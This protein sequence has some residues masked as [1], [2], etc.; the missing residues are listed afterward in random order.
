MAASLPG[1]R[2]HISGSSHSV[3]PHGHFIL[4][5]LHF[6]I[7]LPPQANV[8]SGKVTDPLI[9]LYAFV[10]NPRRH[11]F[12]LVPLRCL[13]GWLD[14]PRGLLWKALSIYCLWDAARDSLE[15]GPGDFY[16]ET[17]QLKA[18]VDVFHRVFFESWEGEAGSAGKELS[19]VGGGLSPPPRFTEQQVEN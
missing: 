9:P 13:E 16:G 8:T 17:S 7:L 5:R 6:L 11:C 10:R 14:S 19:C 18:F 2:K 3:G 4:R 15:G 1:R 12:A